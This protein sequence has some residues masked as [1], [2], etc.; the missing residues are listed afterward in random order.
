MN[1]PVLLLSG[2]PGTGKSSLAQAWLYTFAR[3]LHLPVDTLRELVVSGIAHPSLSADPEATRQFALARRV[4]FLAA[5]LYAREGFAVALDDVWWPHDPDDLNAELLGGLN[6]SRVFLTAPLAT[7]LERNR[8]RTGKPFEPHLLEPIIRALHG[9]MNPADFAA[10]GWHVVGSEGKAL[11]HTL[12]TV[13]QLT[14]TADSA[15]S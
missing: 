7:V 14:Q 13:V 11:A 10:A 3:G 9:S 5:A 4:A 6:V 15:P 2:V 8:T 1:G 12:E